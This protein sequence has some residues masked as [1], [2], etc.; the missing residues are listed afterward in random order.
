MEDQKKIATTFAQNS[1]NFYA[2]NCK[3]SRKN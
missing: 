1:F 3:M 2:R